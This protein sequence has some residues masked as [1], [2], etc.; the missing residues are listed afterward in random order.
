MS[1]PEDQPPAS[2]VVGVNGATAGPPDERARCSSK[3]VL[4]AAAGADHYLKNKGSRLA[5]CTLPR[6]IQYSRVVFVAHLT[7]IG[8][9]Q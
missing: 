7:F 9:T 3:V 5:P 8:N 1:T 2:R 6:T 4:A